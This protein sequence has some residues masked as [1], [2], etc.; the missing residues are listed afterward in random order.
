MADDSEWERRR[1]LRMFGAG[2]A[3]SLAGCSR[4]LGSSDGGSGKGAG[5]ACADALEITEQSARIGPGTIPEVQLSLHNA[6]DVA[7][8]YEVLVVFQQGTS[9]GIDARTG[10]DVL[11]GTL[12]PGETVVETATDDARDVRNT[13]QYELRPSVAC[14]P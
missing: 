2:V 6:G 5:S 14:D 1:Y 10:R 7:L 11:A 9:L 13:D 8:E 3:G 12:D 4:A